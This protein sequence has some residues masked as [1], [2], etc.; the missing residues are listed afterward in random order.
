MAFLWWRWHSQLFTHSATRLLKFS[1]ANC[2]EVDHNWSSR[3]PAEHQP[4]VRPSGRPVLCASAEQAHRREDHP[5]HRHHHGRRGGPDVPGAVQA[6]AAPQ[7]D[8]LLQDRL[9]RPG[10]AELRVVQAAAGPSF[11][12]EWS[13]FRPTPPTVRSVRWGDGVCGP[14]EISGW[15]SSLRAKPPPSVSLLLVNQSSVYISNPRRYQLRWGSNAPVSAS[16]FADISWIG[17]DRDSKVLRWSCFRVKSTRTF[18]V[19]T[20]DLGGHTGF[21]MLHQPG[22]YKINTTWQPARF[23]SQDVLCSRY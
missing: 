5:G 9:L 15:M 2:V 16:L 22:F 12:S 18:E 17:G 1:A 23:S 3:P 4:E 10:H 20:L 8:R 7:E 11:P 14:R 19:I 21:F 13:Q 6:G